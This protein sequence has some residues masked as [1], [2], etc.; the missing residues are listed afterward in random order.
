MNSRIPLAYF[1][2]PS[3]GDL[4]VSHSNRLKLDLWRMPADDDEPPRIQADFE[5]HGSIDLSG[6]AAAE[7][8]ALVRDLLATFRTAPRAEAQEGGEYV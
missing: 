3:P 4:A 8:V 5:L 7:G 1:L 2:P 6:E